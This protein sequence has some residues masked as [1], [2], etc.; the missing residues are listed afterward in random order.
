MKKLWQEFKEFALGGDLV[1][2]A[3]GLVIALALSSV[4]TSLVD[5][6]IMPIVGIIFGEPSFHNLTLT[7]NDSVITYGSFITAAVSF[8]AL[9]AAVYFMIVKPYNALKA[10]VAA[11]EEEAP[12]SPP[13]NI[14]LLREIRD[15]LRQ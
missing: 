3:V 8:V 1:T 12:A 7:I 15:A 9:A 4:V 6:I 11:G 10:R 14:T 13:E 2:V 5:D